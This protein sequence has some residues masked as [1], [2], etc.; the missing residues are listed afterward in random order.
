MIVNG[1]PVADPTSYQIDTPRVANVALDGEPYI[2]WDCTVRLQYATTANSLSVFR[3][4]FSL[5]G[6]R[7]TFTLPGLCE[8]EF[9]GFVSSVSPRIGSQGDVRGCDVEITAVP[10]E[11]IIAHLEQL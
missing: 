10:V 3:V 9:T 11:Q 6:Q 4:W 2:P 1:A 8:T 5:L 7:V